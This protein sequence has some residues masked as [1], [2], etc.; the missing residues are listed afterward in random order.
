MSNSR[1]DVSATN[2]RSDITSPIPR[3]THARLGEED[4]KDSQKK[5]PKAKALDSYTD[6][7]TNPMSLEEEEIEESKMK[8]NKFKAFKEMLMGKFIEEKMQLNLKAGAFHKWLG[9][10]PDS[11]ITDTDIAKGLRSKDPHVVKMASFA[12]ASRKWKHGKK[13]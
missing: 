3:T 12:K 9:K 11:K 8:V 7:D 4:I 13:K 2:N 10:S 6:P 1:V 5:K